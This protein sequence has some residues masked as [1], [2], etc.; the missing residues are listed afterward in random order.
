MRN[1]VYD[2]YTTLQ[3]ELQNNQY[4]TALQLSHG[5]MTN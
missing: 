4:T 5:N 2:N 1:C 3:L